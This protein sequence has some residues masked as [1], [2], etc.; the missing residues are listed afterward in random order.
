MHLTVKLNAKEAED[1]IPLIQQSISALS[2]DEAK[3]ISIKIVKENAGDRGFFSLPS[4]NEQQGVAEIKGG[5]ANWYRYKMHLSVRTSNTLAR[6]KIF[7][8]ELDQLKDDNILEILGIGKIDAH[9]LETDLIHIFVMDKARLRNK[10]LLTPIKHRETTLRQ[11]G[12]LKTPQIPLLKITY[13]GEPHRLFLLSKANNTPTTYP[14]MLDI[15][16]I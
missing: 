2:H 11:N 15:F 5:L 12:A 1:V 16:G 9:K 14:P 6:R 13:E 3:K 8:R 10:Q 4:E 7:P